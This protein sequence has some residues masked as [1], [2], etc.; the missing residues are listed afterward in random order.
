EMF[1]KDAPCLDRKNTIFRERERASPRRRPGSDQAH[2]DQVKMLVRTLEPASSLID[3][4]LH[5]RK[6]RNTIE[7]AKA[8]GEQ[9]NK[10]WIELNSRYIAESEI[11]GG[12]QVPAAADT[13]YCCSS[14]MTN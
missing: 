2:L 11:R 12:K 1:E 6:T 14:G 5:A 13:N 9:V 3:V 4:K 8:A 10:Y 7:V